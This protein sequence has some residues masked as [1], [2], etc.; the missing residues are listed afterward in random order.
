MIVT[1]ITH[2][3][4]HKASEDPSAWASAPSLV[5]EKFAPCSN[6]LSSYTCSDLVPSHLCVM[7]LLG[8][9][10]SHFPPIASS[11]TCS[12][13]RPSASSTPLTGTRSLLCASARWSGMSGSIVLQIRPKTQLWWQPASWESLL[14]SQRRVPRSPISSHLAPW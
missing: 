5:G 2:F 9:L 8:V 13:S 1:V 6:K 12:L 3:S 11:P 4:A 7:S 14:L 10:V